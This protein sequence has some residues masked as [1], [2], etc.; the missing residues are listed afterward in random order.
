[1][2]NFNKQ[3]L[4][5]FMASFYILQ[6]NFQYDNRLMRVCKMCNAYARLSSGIKNQCCQ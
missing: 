3:Q 6:S 4:F 2:I 5:L 1:M